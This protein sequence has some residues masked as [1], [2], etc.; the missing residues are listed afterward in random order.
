MS[1][2]IVA[3][4]GAEPLPEN[5]ITVEREGYRYCAHDR[6]TL[7]EHVRTVRCTDCGKVFEPFDYLLSNALSIQR[8]WLS[9]KEVMRKASEKAETVEALTKEEKRLKARVKL[10]KEKAE[11]SIDIKGKWL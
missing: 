5:P 4:P 8:A 2:K 3:F 11:P 10:L 7:D 9:H 6:I 1:D